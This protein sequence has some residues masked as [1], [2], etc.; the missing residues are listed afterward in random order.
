M[1]V[2]TTTTR[3]T[4]SNRASGLVTAVVAAVLSLGVAYIHVKDQGGIPGDKEPHYVGIG[5]WI[6]EIAGVV[7]ALLLLAPATRQRVG[8]WVLA[9]GV[10]LG[11]LVG[12]IWSRGPGMPDYTD[13]RGNWT[14]TLG[15]VSLIVEGLLIVVALVGAARARSRSTIV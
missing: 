3:T 9:L 11:P 12:Y 8:S 1:S 7:A 15:L 2:S 14:E 6:L 10:G 5:Y 13:D 4:A